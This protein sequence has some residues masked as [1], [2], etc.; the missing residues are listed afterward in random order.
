M[1]K[2]EADLFDATGILKPQ[3]RTTGDLIATFDVDNPQVLKDLSIKSRKQLSEIHRLT[4]GD[5]SKNYVRFFRSS[6]EPAI[7]QIRL[8]NTNILKMKEA[9]FEYNTLVEQVLAGDLP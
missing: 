9:K 3:G 2:Q 4:G 1:T 5:G 7:E 6:V 8:R